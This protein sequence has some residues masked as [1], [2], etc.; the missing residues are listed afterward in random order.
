MIADTL[1]TTNR[2]TD[3]IS[4]QLTIGNLDLGK[5]REQ[6]KPT[7][8]YHLQLPSLLFLY[9]VFLCPYCTSMSTN[10]HMNVYKKQK[11]D[12][13]LRLQIQSQ[14]YVLILFASS[15]YGVYR[16]HVDEFYFS[17][18]KIEKAVPPVD[19]CRRRFG[20]CCREI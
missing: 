13:G 9:A 2:R 4:Y 8:V 1:K 5:R 3:E 17:L 15:C 14:F 18:L 10:L 12:L 19:L 20:P 6:S 16:Y 7:C 11:Y